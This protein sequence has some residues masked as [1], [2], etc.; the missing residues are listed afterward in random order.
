MVLELLVQTTHDNEF[1]NPWRSRE[2]TSRS[3]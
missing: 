1:N 2:A 3:V